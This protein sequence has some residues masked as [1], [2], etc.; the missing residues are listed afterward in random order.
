MPLTFGAGKEEALSSTGSSAS[1]DWYSLIEVE[2]SKM[3]GAVA[4]YQPSI[5]SGDDG[6]KNTKPGPHQVQGERAT[7][8]G[9]TTMEDL[10]VFHESQWAKIVDCMQLDYWADAE[11]H[12]MELEQ[13]ST[14]FLGQNQAQLSIDQ[15]R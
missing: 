8:L 7:P 11:E 6:E 15:K 10:Q 1:G 12:L 14:W 3:E 5:S 9:F 2:S 13:A 4:K